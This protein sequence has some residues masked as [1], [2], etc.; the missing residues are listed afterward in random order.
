MEQQ[1]IEEEELILIS[2][3][4]V[5]KN[6]QIRILLVLLFILKLECFTKIEDTR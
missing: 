6:S 5:G 2:P 1:E 4:I 3:R